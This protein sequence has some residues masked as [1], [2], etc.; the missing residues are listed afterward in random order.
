[1]YF[2]E[3]LFVA[4]TVFLSG[5]ILADSTSQKERLALVFAGAQS[6][7]KSVCGISARNTAP[8]LPSK[9]AL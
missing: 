7:L 5:L 9:S 3:I 1:M 2:S 4:K 8:E 6:N